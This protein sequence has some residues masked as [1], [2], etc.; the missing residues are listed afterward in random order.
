[1]LS[2]L[3]HKQVP[4]AELHCHLEGAASPSFIAAIAR[5]KGLTIDGLIDA[6][7][8]YIWSDFAS[9]IDAYGRVS[10]CLGAPEDLSALTYDYARSVARD[11][12]IYLEVFGSLAHAQES[13]LSFASYVDAIADGLER[14]EAEFGLVGRIIMVVVRQLGPE[15]ALED[16][17]AIVKADHPLVSGFGMAGDE[18]YGEV[19]AYAPA[20][21]VAREAGLGLTIHAGEFGGPQSVRQALDVIKPSRLG[22]GVRAIE[23]PELVRRLVDERIV[24]EV[25]PGSNVALGVYKDRASHPFKALHQA[26]VRV[27]LN[28][29]DP[30]FFGTSLG[31]EYENARTIDRLTKKQLKAITARAIEAAFVDAP[32]RIRL[33]AMAQNKRVPSI[34]PSPNEPR[35]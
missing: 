10:S 27:T 25:C 33:L 8:R 7:G 30:P 2:F 32:T 22:H 18:L 5:R 19:S 3:R 9:F 26:G 16:A 31:A 1:M 14:A 23:D 21:D 20:F 29:D 4:K 34:L 28:S 35:P 12:G 17:R 13:G 15:K 11:N 6:D 24:L